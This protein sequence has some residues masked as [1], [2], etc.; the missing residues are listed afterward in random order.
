MWSIKCN[1]PAMLA[2]DCRRIGDDSH[3]DD[4]YIRGERW[5]SMFCYGSF[6]DDVV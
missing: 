5:V 3:D 6:E 2:E 4:V 1:V